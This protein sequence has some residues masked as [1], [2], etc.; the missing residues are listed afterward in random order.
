[1]AVRLAIAIV[2][3]I[4]TLLLPGASAQ[5]GAPPDSSARQSLQTACD[6]APQVRVTTSKS[7]FLTHSPRVSADGFTIPAPTAPQALI[8]IGDAGPHAKLVP[9]SEIDRLESVHSRTLKYTAAGF[10]TGAVL[11]GMMVG[12]NGPDAFEEGDNGMVAY[13]G[14]VTLGFTA[15]GMLLGMLN[16]EMKTLYP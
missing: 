1:M 9:W 2:A 8:T 7:M 16:P 11:G 3:V 14:V 13:A 5:A 10:V 15:A 4:M 12:I 6:A